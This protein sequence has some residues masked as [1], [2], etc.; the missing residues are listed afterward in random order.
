MEEDPMVIIELRMSE[1]LETVE[2]L[3]FASEEALKMGYDA[4][5]ERSTYYK[6]LAEVIN[7]QIEKRG[8]EPVGR[9]NDTNGE[10]GPGKILP[11]RKNNGG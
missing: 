5:G 10:P 7:S 1:A 11:F 3:H 2:G 8:P 6:I 4:S 9:T